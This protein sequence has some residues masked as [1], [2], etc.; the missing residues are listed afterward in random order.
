MTSDTLLTACALLELV[1]RQGGNTIDIDDSLTLLAGERC[2]HASVS[3]YLA[4]VVVN[5]CK[6]ADFNLSEFI[7]SER[8][9]ALAVEQPDPGGMA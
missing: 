2:A 5:V 9:A 4:A 1:E 6:D 8:A 3:L 7:S